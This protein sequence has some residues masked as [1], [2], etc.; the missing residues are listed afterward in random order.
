[1]IWKPIREVAGK[2]EVSD[3]GL[4]RNAATQ[5]VL[6]PFTTKPGEAG[7]YLVRMY[8]GSK[9]DRL[10]HR[11]VAAEFLREVAGKHEINHKNGNKKDNRVANLEWCDRSYNVRE[12]HRMHRYA[13]RGENGAA[14]KMTQAQVEAARIAYAKGGVTQQKLGEKYGVSQVA[15]SKI[16][17]RVTYK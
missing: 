13:L 4:V 1:M 3:L 8:H 15:M 5:Q 16:L 11:L 10:V 9:Y 2:Y 17:R 14:S 7:Y 6:R 12:G